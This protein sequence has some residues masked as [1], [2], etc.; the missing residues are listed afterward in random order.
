M[1]GW[2]I[3]G[4][5]FFDKSKLR[6]PKLVVGDLQVAQDEVEDDDLPHLI[7][8]EMLYKCTTNTPVLVRM[9]SK[10]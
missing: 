10:M 5:L 7:D 3:P 6:A 1:Q 2:Y 4:C 8:D 9:R